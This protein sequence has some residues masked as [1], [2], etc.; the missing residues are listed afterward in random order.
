MAA[1]LK[2][3]GKDP[4]KE[5]KKTCK[6][7]LS[8]RRERFARRGGQADDVSAAIAKPLV[9]IR[10]Y[11]KVWWSC[12]GNQAASPGAPERCGCRISYSALATFSS[13]SGITFFCDLEIVRYS[14]NR[15]ILIVVILS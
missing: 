5:I 6:R 7:S 15:H 11:P 8:Y 1:T 14:E 2:K 10:Y 9:H 12:C 13:S 3:Q 4:K